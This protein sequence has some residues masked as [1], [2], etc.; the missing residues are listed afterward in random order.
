VVTVSPYLAINLALKS[1][2]DW[3]QVAA[4]K[5]LYLMAGIADDHNVGLGHNGHWAEY[6]AVCVDIASSNRM[7]KSL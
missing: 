2:E 1:S 7:L 5:Y 4:M 3:V 6:L